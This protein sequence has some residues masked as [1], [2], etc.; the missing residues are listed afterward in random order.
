MASRE[1]V[2]LTSS[3]PT[4]S[5]QTAQDSQSIPP[6]MAALPCGTKNAFV[7]LVTLAPHLGQ[8]P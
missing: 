3:E 1:H 2:W 4:G 8:S 5:R 6:G 7:S